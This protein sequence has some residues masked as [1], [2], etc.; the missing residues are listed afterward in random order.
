MLDFLKKIGTLFRNI[1][2]TARIITGIAIIIAA[3]LVSV[4]NIPGKALAVFSATVGSCMGM[5]VLLSAVQKIAALNHKIDTEALN[6]EREARLKMQETEILLHKKDSELMQLYT[7]NERLKKMKIDI[8]TVQLAMQ[9]VFLEMHTV[10]KDIH[11][12]P[13]ASVE[14]PHIFRGLVDYITEEYLGIATIRFTAKIGIDLEH[15]RV[16]ST[17]EALIISG[18][19]CKTIGLIDR[20]TT[21][22]LNEIRRKIMCDGKIKSYEIVADDRIISA[23]KDAQMA[24]IEQ[25]LNAGVEVYQSVENCVETMG[26]HFITLLLSPFKGSKIIEFTHTKP[27]GT[28]LFEFIQDHNGTIDELIHK[29]QSLLEN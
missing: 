5:L 25:K 7:E 4:L 26:E 6:S 28:P 18:I 24:T 19:Q 21:W 29:E 15:I 10:L 12:K 11:I 20:E 8:N 14:K 16:F 13:L 17:N 3:V 2:Y 9:M 23:E 27:V 22:V 1:G